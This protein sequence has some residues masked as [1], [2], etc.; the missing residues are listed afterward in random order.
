MRT[1][2]KLGGFFIVEILVVL[3]IIG[4]LV[5]AL[6]PNLT[7]YTQRAQ[8]VD[9]LSVA[10]A[11]KPA[12][13]GCLMQNIGSTTNCT[14]GATGTY[15]IPANQTGNL[16]SFVSSVTV[17]NGIITV[18]SAT[19]KFG[20]PVSAGSYTYILTPTVQTG[21]AITWV[22]TGTCQNAGLC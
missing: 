17:T 8:Y 18:T 11:I 14:P 6:M 22:P 13:E 5:T 19:G 2:K 1:V 21:G 20:A 12:V 15:G 10:G 7:V 16:G 3:L 4:I 9:N